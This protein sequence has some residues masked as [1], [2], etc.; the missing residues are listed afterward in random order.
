MMETRLLLKTDKIVT[1][2]EH[3]LFP[4][5]FP[6][7]L[8]ILCAFWHGESYVKVRFGNFFMFAF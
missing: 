2:T 4:M 6:L 7:F 3:K 8:V 1:R 5:H